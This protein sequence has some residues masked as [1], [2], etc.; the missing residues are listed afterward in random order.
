MLPWFEPEIV[1]RVL[2]PAVHR[3]RLDANDA[4]ANCRAVVEGQ[5]LSMRRHSAW[6]GMRPDRL[7]ATGGAAA[8]R[9]ILQVIADIHRCPVYRHGAAN[10]AALG[11]AIRAV[12]AVANQADWDELIE[13]F[14]PAPSEP[15]AVPRPNTAACYAEAE[16][17]YGR[18]EESALRDRS[19]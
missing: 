15:A 5:A 6:M 7:Y 9:D 16:D 4:A 1:P 11:A 19:A 12:E 8:N 2:V 3:I 10:S 13:R 17:A 14:A 18:A